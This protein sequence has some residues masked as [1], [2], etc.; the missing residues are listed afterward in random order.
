MKKEVDSEF[1]ELLVLFV[2]CIILYELM[3]SHSFI[4][5]DI[6]IIEVVTNFIKGTL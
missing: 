1:V 5:S 6:S 4:S 3:F 2:F